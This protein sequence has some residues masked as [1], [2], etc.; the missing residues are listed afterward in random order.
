MT[1]PRQSDLDADMILLK[2]KYFVCMLLGIVEETMHLL[3]SNDRLKVVIPYYEYTSWSATHLLSKTK[4]QDNTSI[5]SR[6][7]Y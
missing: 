2:V 5:E 1:N 7:Y 4:L 3:N 6:N